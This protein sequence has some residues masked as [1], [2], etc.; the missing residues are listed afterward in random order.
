MR[1]G[2]Q[3]QEH[4]EGNRIQYNIQSE[5]EKTWLVGKKKNEFSNLLNGN[6]N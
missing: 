3:A 2:E 1:T 5:Q 6:Y 4:I